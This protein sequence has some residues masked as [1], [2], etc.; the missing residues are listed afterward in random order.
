MRCGVGFTKICT[1]WFASA[2]LTLLG[3]F[4]P[5][6]LVVLGDPRKLP[7]NHD[8]DNRAKPHRGAVR[9]GSLSESSRMQPPSHPFWVACLSLM[10]A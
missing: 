9:G 4:C 2:P 10:I 8:L 6:I 7:K 5:Q 3:A 1:G